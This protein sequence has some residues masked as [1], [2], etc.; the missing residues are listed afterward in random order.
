MNIET[1]WLI[2]VTVDDDTGEVDTFPFVEIRDSGIVAADEIQVRASEGAMCFVRG[3]VPRCTIWT[4]R[5]IELL[6]EATREYLRRAKER[7]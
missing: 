3:G 1:N 2:H 4:R 5:G 6:H 7:D